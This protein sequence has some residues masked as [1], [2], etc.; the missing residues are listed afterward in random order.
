MKIAFFDSGIGGLTVLHQAM[1]LLPGEQFVFLADEDHV[2]YGVKPR[3]EVL[4]YVLDVADFLV[5]K[6]VKAIVIACNTATSVGLEELRRRHSVPIFGMEPAVAKALDRD[7]D[8][9]VLVIATNIT[10]KGKMLQ[11][12]IARV[13]KKG[14]V[15]T[16]PMPKLV[17]FAE[18]MNFN[19]PEVKAYL[20]KQFVPY[21]LSQ[22]STLVLGCTHFNYFKDT[23]REVLPANVCMTDA[24]DI[25]LGHLIHTLDEKGLR[26]QLPNAEPEYYYT[27]RLVTDPKEL[28]RLQAYLDRLEQVDKIK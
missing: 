5:K 4:G 22:Y 18:A 24:C 15:D 19:G 21:D 14:L 8:H 12:Q 11:D 1:K 26:E 16:L 6:N 28:T 3:E 17:E 13:D 9:R 23:L 7:P 20:E 10:C 2:P 25:V 27:D